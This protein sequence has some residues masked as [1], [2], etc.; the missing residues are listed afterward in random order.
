MSNTE[1]ELAREHAGRSE[2]DNLLLLG[3][4]LALGSLATLLSLSLL[5][6]LLCLRGVLLF[7]L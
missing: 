2:M 6:L 5:L 7:V 4:T 3:L 1:N